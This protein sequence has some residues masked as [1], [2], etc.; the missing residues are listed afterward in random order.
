[1]LQAVSSNQ[2]AKFNPAGFVV[3]ENHANWTSIRAVFGDHMIN[4]VVSCE[5][6]FKK[7]VC[8]HGKE[9]APSDEKTFTTIQYNFIDLRRRNSPLVRLR[10]RDA[11]H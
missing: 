11:I 6:H 8:R 2:Q 3:D 7:S 9:L 5:V 4:R 10:D 1:M